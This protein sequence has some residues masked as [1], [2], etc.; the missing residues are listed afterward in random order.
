MGTM[1]TKVAVVS[2]FF[3]GLFH[4]LYQGLVAPLMRLFLLEKLYELKRRLRPLYR[5][6]VS[7]TEEVSILDKSI[8]TAIQNLDKFDIYII[9]T[10]S[11]HVKAKTQLR[12]ETIKRNNGIGS[13]NDP[14]L[15]SIANLFDDYLLRALMINSGGLLLWLAP[16]LSVVYL[17]NRLITTWSNR[18][19]ATMRSTVFPSD[20]G[21]VR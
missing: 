1:I 6:T 13:P 20:Y 5:S 18:I 8:E 3:L 17:R 10:A 2:F 19:K 21:V 14:N 4:Y 11:R 9:Y 7:N 12:N 15:R 16:L